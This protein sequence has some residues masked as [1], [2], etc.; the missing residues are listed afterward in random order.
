MAELPLET[1]DTEGEH[2][3]EQGKTFEPTDVPTK[4]TPKQS[5]DG[6]EPIVLSDRYVLNMT[7]PL[8]QFDSP[9]A[10]SY[11]AEDSHD[12]GQKLFVLICPPNIPSRLESIHKQSST[13][14]VGLLDIID[15]GVVYWPP[16]GQSTMV[17]IFKQPLGGRVALKLAQKEIIITEY[18]I[19]KILLDPLTKTL[20]KLTDQDA[21]HRA[22]R[23]EN[24]F[25]NNE[26][27]TEI[28][29][30]ENLSTPPGYDQPLIYEPIER[31]MSNRAGRGVGSTRDDIFA[32]GVTIGILILGQNPVAKI[33]DGDLIQA[34]LEYGSYAVIFGNSRVPLAL[35][36]PLQ[37]MLNDDPEAR[38]DFNE[39]SNWLDGKRTAPSKKFISDKAETP[40]SFQGQEYV[41]PRLLAYNFGQQIPNSVKAAQSQAFDIWLLR[42]LGRKEMA[43]AVKDIFD[44]AKFHPSGYQGSLE[45]ISFRLCMVLDPL[46]PIHYKNITF[47]P[48]GFGPLLA[49]ELLHNNNIEF[50]TT[51]LTYD[52]MPT[53]L[54]TKN[55]PFPGTSDLQKNF[56]ALKG[57]LEINEYGYGLERVL[58]EINIGQPCHNH[59]ILND[60]VLLIEDLLPAIE[61]ASSR[62]D[63]SQIPI[64][65]HIAAFIATH[66]KHDI[67]PHLKAFGSKSRGTSIIGLLSLLAFLQWKLHEQQMLGLSSWIGGLLGPA[68]NIY[69]NRKTRGELEKE[70]PRLV[71]K[72]RLPE[73]FSL[74]DNLDRRNQDL[75]GYNKAKL[76]WE[77]AEEEVKDIEGGGNIR[78]MKAEKAGQ[79]TAG[80]FSIII[81]L[82]FLSA[83]LIIQTY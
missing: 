54:A 50:G 81:A 76:E 21:P 57:F 55:P 65:K 67:Y 18:D 11:L 37:G 59:L 61:R 3:H 32:L 10:K 19:P 31:A 66:F 51:V 29:I 44:N 78:I 22:I 48:D 74:V 64:D 83:M 60:Y 1:D 27:M 40:F 53:W 79:Q 63:T 49:T 82:T 33:K 69:H 16:L 42:S 68:I 62:A 36:E 77:V 14:S 34:R 75:L 47:M 8:P 43:E 7:T 20:Q 73:L 72:G 52:I 80:I 45:H 28:V 5:S 17:I 26:E 41:N 46:G 35:I 15:W 12:S 70:I 13:D 24:I 71:R 30:G 9:S 39:I 56:S 58:Y 4:N 2:P 6:N 25:F 23:P 38:W